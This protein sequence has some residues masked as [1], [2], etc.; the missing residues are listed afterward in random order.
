MAIL[1]RDHLH[2]PVQSPH[3][4][5]GRYL[6][7]LNR[8]ITS[9]GMDGQ[10]DGQMS[11]LR[12]FQVVQA[13]K[14]SPQ[15]NSI[16]L[17]NTLRQRQNGHHFPDGIFQCIFK[18]ENPW[19]LLKISLKFVPMGPINNIPA[20]FQI[21]AWRLPGDKPSSEPMMVKLLTHICVTWS[22]RVYVTHHV[23]CNPVWQK[24]FQ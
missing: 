6:I 10:T 14:Q 1:P 19:I 11:A 3:K 22:Q 2:G 12:F 13:Y 7:Y 15:T 20:L 24:V 4:I 23:W 21:M 5:S 8:E 17:F 9:F 16:Y 18:N